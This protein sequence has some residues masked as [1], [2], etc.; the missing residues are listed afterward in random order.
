MKSLICI[1]L[2]VFTLNI[3]NLSAANY[4]VTSNQ[5]TGQ[6]TLRWAINQAN[7]SIGLDTIKFNISSSGQIIISPL[8]ELPPITDP[9]FIDGYSQPGNVD[10]N[11]N[12]IL[13][14][15]LFSYQKKYGLIVKTNIFKVKGLH[16]NDFHNIRLL[17]LIK[18]ILDQYT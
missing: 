15:N 17:N 13:S 11:I 9:L 6:A 12:L 3:N 2:C 16:F 4:I 1:I 8:N 18:G 10:T 7:S 14:G 5:D